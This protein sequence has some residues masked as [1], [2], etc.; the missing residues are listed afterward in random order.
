MW[1]ISQPSLVFN[2]TS[3]TPSDQKPALNGLVLK[4]RNREVRVLER[5]GRDYR[6]FGIELLEDADGD[7]MDEI[8]ENNSRAADM[9]ME[10]VRGWLRGKGKKPVTWRTLIEVLRKIEL[11]ELA[12]DIT[13][14]LQ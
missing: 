9:R 10:I 1:A 5:I 13:D 11:D 2:L 3:S 7:K 6:E 4:K 8:K 12:D 14:A